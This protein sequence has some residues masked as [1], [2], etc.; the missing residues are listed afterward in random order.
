MQ[1]WRAAWRIPLRGLPILALLAILPYVV[2]L[3]QPLISDDYLQIALGR[4]YGPVSGWSAL[5]GDALYRARATSLVVTYWTERLFGASPLP[6]YASAILLHVL[7][8]W[9]VFALASRLGLGRRM[10]LCAAAFFAIYEGHQEAVMWYAALPELL[11]FTFS[12]V[13]LILRSP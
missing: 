6:L 13:A 10:G 9:L 5:A 3:D 7:N 12:L 1:G 11:V 2:V 4:Q 8:S